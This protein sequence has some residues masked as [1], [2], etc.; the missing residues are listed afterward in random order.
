MSI[1]G[2]GERDDILKNLLLE[3]ANIWTGDKERPHAE[4][5]LVTGNR[6]VGV[7]SADTLMNLP[8]ARYATK[9]CLKGETI[10][11]GMTDSHMHLSTL[12][13]GRIALDLSSIRSL[14]E[15]LHILGEEAARAPE[16]SW[17]YGV[18]F[19]ETRWKDP[20]IPTRRDLDS[21]GLS[22]PVLLQR[23]CTH[24]NVANTVALSTSGFLDEVFPEG[25]YLNEQGEPT[26]VLAERAAFSLYEK[27]MASLNRAGIMEDLLEAT[28]RDLAKQ[29][30]TSV[31]PCGAAFYGMGEDIGLYQSLDR[32]KRLPV[33]IFSYHDRM[34]N[35]GIK[36][37]LGNGHVTYQGWKTFLDG[38]LGARTAALSQ[39]YSDDPENRGKLNFSNEELKEQ[40]EEVFERGLQP[41]IHSIGDA[42]LDQALNV[43]ENLLPLSRDKL[44]FPVRI[45]HVQV[46][47]PDQVER[48]AKLGVICDVQPTFLTS[49]MNI[50]PD[51]LGERMDWAY[52]WKRLVGAGLTL[53][54]SSDAPVET[55][56]PMRG[57]WAA[58]CRTGEDGKPERGWTPSQKLT[59]DEA[60]RLYTTGPARAIGHSDDLGRIAPGYFADF[61]ILDENI[62]EI[63]EHRLK[64]VNVLATFMGGIQTHGKPL[65]N[66]RL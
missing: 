38:T 15:L 44:D 39:P 26:G 20:V 17:I 41:L 48:L 36:S 52:A 54:G 49:D 31:H 28:C 23:V 25:V 51:R 24:I 45:N 19:N 60:L 30:I 65:S 14:Q 33:R 11:P 63:S 66:L 56:S 37:G 35:L 29:G 55:P 18:C 32:Q 62:F 64:D 21:L 3:G 1:T 16:D 9:C 7:G 47:R 57:I 42:A 2:G 27:L 61:A 4:S 43:L 46:C 12:A 8:E 10:L 22:Q 58:V 5:V 34:P 53:T 59:L 13:R 40:L 50:A 6:I